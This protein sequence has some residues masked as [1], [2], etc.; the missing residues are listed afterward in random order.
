VIHVDVRI[1]AATNKNLKEEI[2]K[3]RFRE[4]LYHRLS[5][6][7]MRV[8]SLDERKEDIPLLTDHFNQLICQEYGISPRSFTQDAIEELKGI[9]WTGNIREFRNVLERLIILCG[10]QITGEDVKNFA[11]PISG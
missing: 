6:I 1:L 10:Q 2:E 11:Q 5:V 9:S 8:P 3:N 4:D 7:L